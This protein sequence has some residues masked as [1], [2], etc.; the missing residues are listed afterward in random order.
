MYSLIAII[1]LIPL[2]FSHVF[3][4]FGVIIWESSSF[5]RQKVYLFFFLILLGLVEQFYEKMV[6]TKNNPEGNQWSNIWLW[7]VAGSIILLPW[8]SSG[9]YHQYENISGW[10]L[11][12]YEKRHGSVFFL[13]I[14][15]YGY[16]LLSRGREELKKLMMISTWVAGGVAFFA[17]FEYIFGSVFFPRLGEISWEIGRTISTLGNPNYVAGYL[18]LHLGLLRFQRYE[19]SFPL[20]IIMVGAIVTTGSYIAMG[21]IMIEVCW[22]VFHRYFSWKISLFITSLITIVWMILGYIFIDHDKLLSLLSRFILMY[23][24]L[25]H[26]VQYPFS[27]LIWFGPDSILRYYTEYRS[28]LIQSY[29]PNHMAIDSLHNFWLDIIY[30]FGIL[31][32]IGLVIF[33]KKSITHAKEHT[34]LV[35]TLVLGTIFLWLNVMILSH[36]IVFL[37]IFIYLWKSEELSK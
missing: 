16:L 19:I 24:G 34:T 20:S 28:S 25:A 23:D 6:R 32:L 22:T 11:G 36:L 27:F 26:M 33:C 17:I 12:G 21:L 9:V 1:V 30:Q 4:P 5:E 2:Y 37:L 18:L 13:A 8:I 29:F 35:L 14:L 31:P 15:A 3:S 10:I 7:I